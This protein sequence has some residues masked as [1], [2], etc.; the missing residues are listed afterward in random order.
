MGE[1]TLGLGFG[2]NGLVD[3]AAGFLPFFSPGIPEARP[4]MSDMPDFLGLPPVGTA[5][6]LRDGVPLGS[7]ELRRS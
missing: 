7:R 6:A 1:E 5:P 3:A 2:D 4:F